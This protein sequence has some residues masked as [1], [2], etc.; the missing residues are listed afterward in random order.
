MDFSCSPILGKAREK[1]MNTPISP[2]QKN[3]NASNAWIF[4]LALAA[5]LL[6]VSVWGIPLCRDIF[7]TYMG[8][9]SVPG[10]SS[11]ANLA[12]WAAWAV[13][14]APLAIGG[15]ALVWS[16]LQKRGR[17]DQVALSMEDRVGRPD[18]QLANT[19]Q[20]GGIARGG[21]P[22]DPHGLES[23]SAE[24]AE[25][26]QRTAARAA[27]ILGA[28]TGAS[29]L[30]I[31]IVGLVSLFFFSPLP[32]GTITFALFSGMLVFPGFAILQRAFH[33]DSNSWLLPL[34]LFTHIVLKRRGEERPG[35]TEQQPP[36]TKQLPRV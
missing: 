9:G 26:L 11:F 13:F 23:L 5:L 34:R 22:G 4:R 7:R 32:A 2:H 17:L 14:F 3:G 24:T 27:T 18:R 19:I 1:L 16:T 6:G 35:L 8:P 36:R 29:L 20:F 28:L 12:A 25:R 10:D 30:C 33:R 15:A 31:G 21:R